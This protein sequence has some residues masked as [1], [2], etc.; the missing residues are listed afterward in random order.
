MGSSFTKSSTPFRLNEN[1]D[2]E[3]V[4]IIAS[5]VDSD[6]LDYELTKDD[7]IHFEQSSEGIISINIEPDY[8]NPQ[9]INNDNIYSILYSVSD[10]L[11]STNYDLN[12]II[13]DV[14]YPAQLLKEFQNPSCKNDGYF[15][16]NTAIDGDGDTLIMTG[17]TS[18]GSENK[19]TYAYNKLDTNK[20]LIYGEVAEWL[21]ALAC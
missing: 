14:N 16:A 7:S 12:L 19:Y 20:C 4:Q 11:I 17:R 5:D 13:D 21:K 8:E 15:G 2:G 6:D 10:G 3:I 1:L 18:C 9:D